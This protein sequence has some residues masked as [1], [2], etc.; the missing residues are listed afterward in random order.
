MR[1]GNETDEEYI[2]RLERELATLRAEVARLE[3]RLSDASW[4]EFPEAM[5]R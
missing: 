5:G 3:K 2:E 1:Y 4:R